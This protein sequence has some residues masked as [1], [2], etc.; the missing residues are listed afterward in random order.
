MIIMLEK[1]KDLIDFPGTPVIIFVAMLIVDSILHT[2]QAFTLS[3]VICLALFVI[4]V[5]SAIKNF[6]YYG[7]F[8]KYTCVILCA[9]TALFLYGEM[10]SDEATGNLEESNQ[11][12][13]A[14]SNNYYDYNYNYGYDNHYDQDDS[15]TM[16]CYRCH[17][18]GKCEDCGGSGKSK[19][20][21]V[22]GASG[23]ALCDASGRCYKCGGKGYTVH[24]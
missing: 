12:N 1:L 7:T 17:G 5:L 2:M 15:F 19:L 4:M 23:C 11:Y 21:G 18:S 10:P 9:V 8:M 22:L 16:E 20:T 3:F 24:Y 13:S 14:A 6:I